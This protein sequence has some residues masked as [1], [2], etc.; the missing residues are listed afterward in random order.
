MSAEA[1]RLKNEINQC[2]Q[3]A[4]LVDALSALTV[5]L[6]WY[7]VKHGIT[8]EELRTQVASAYDATDRELA[9]YRPS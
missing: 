7:A 5:V 9:K 3:G 8:K 1:R 4:D 6:C 2:V